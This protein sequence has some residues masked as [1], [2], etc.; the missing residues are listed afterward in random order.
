MPGSLVLVGGD[1]GIGKSTLMLQTLE[2]LARQGQTTLY[3]S[4][5]ESATERGCAASASASRT[6]ASYCLRRPT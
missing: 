1:P 6:R 3:I 4:G 5:E 2:A